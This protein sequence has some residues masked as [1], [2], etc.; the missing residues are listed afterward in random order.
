MK[1]FT[2]NFLLPTST[3][4]IERAK[5]K[6]TIVTALA[7]GGAMLALVLFWIVTFTLEDIETVFL[8]I[9]L[10]LLMAGVIFLVKRG[11]IQLGAWILVL[12]MIFLNLSN[13]TWY[14]VSTTSSA[15]YLIPILLAL[16]GIGSAAGFG[17]TLFGC[18]SVF[19]ISLFASTGQ[20]QT[21]IPYA[22]SHLTFDAPALTLIYLIVYFISNAWVKS[23]QEAFTE[24]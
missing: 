2:L 13:M 15:G 3:S 9:V 4:P 1:P 24:K 18:A 16:F 23:A 20:I 8:T 11:R 5:A 22:E 12:L 10:I 7:I 21:E 6:V 19:A 14:G 17:V